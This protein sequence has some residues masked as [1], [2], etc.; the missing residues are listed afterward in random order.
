MSSGGNFAD[1]FQARNAADL[2]VF[3]TNER[4]LRNSNHLERNN[5]ALFLACRNGADKICEV[6]I[7][8]GADVNYVVSQ[9]TPLFI[10][11]Y[12][13]HP[14]CVNLLLA[15]GAE[16]SPRNVADSRTPLLATSVED[17]T[18]VGSAL[19]QFIDNRCLCMR[20]L[21]D[22]GVVIDQRNNDGFTAL[23]CATWNFRLT[24]ILVKA[25]ADVNILN[26][27]R[28]SSL[29]VASKGN[30]ENV[31]QLLVEHGAAI[32]AVD[33]HGST[34][35]HFACCHFKPAVVDTL[36]HQCADIDT[37]NND[38]YTAL[39]LAMYRPVTSPNRVDV[40]QLMAA[41]AQTRLEDSSADWI[42]LA[43]NE[44][45]RSQMG[46]TG[47]ARQRRRRHI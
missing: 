40:L 31:V 36:L 14:A 29:H 10:A 45:S 42:R 6:L 1:F 20:L 28:I 47:T 18:Q 33:V 43:R 9:S 5:E 46:S 32:D 27:I 2:K 30:D 41:C 16:T 7:I 37:V 23:M 12:F 24:E 22:A 19:D 44:R 4:H 3:M 17:V 25:G 34:P 8:F 13:A 39:Q 15:H 35:L 38:G 11:C 26:N 21:L